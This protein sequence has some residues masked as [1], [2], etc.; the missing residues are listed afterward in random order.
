MNRNE[1]R[2]QEK[3]NNE[4]ANWYKNLVPSKKNFIM[5]A[6]EKQVIENDRITSKILD[7]CFVAA[8][9]EKLGLSL[10][11]CEEIIDISNKN[12]QDTK[13]YLEEKGKEGITMINDE[14]LRGKIRE[15]A[16][17]LQRQGMKIAAGIKELRKVYNF[18]Q[19][20]IHIIWAEGREELKVEKEVAEEKEEPIKIKGKITNVKK[21]EEEIPYAVT[22]KEI[23]EGQKAIPVNEAVK[24]LGT[25]E[26]EF[27][28]PNKSKLEIISQTTVIKGEYAT[29]E[30]NSEG[31][32]TTFGLYKGIEDVEKCKKVTQEEIK[33][34]RESLN[35]QLSEIQCSLNRLEEVEKEE[36]EK[37]EEIKA[38]FSL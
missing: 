1:R 5:Y 18:P 34:N 36:M 20:D 38:V 28:N 31:V 4:L 25:V 16:K 17:E 23:E 11:D 6:I 14:K 8:M 12:I 21:T 24:E 13:N 30:K 10:K 15:E 7:S 27:V 9:L 29:Y 33:A 26:T 19:K 3:Q 22:E 35:N 32:K 2:S 37:Y